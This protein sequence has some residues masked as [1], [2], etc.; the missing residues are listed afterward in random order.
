MPSLSAPV[1]SR[2]QVPHGTIELLAN[3]V[4]VT[5]V[6]CGLID[7]MCQDPA[8]GIFGITPAPYGVESGSG[9]DEFVGADHIVLVDV[10]NSSDGV[11]IR[12]P[13]FGIGVGVPIERVFDIFPGEYFLKPPDLNPGE[14][15]NDAQQRRSRVHNRPLG[16]F[17]IEG[18]EFLGHDGAQV[19]QNL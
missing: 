12:H 6:P 13:K 17:V 5:G 14:V 7:H 15:V 1:G 3:D 19:P 18:S 10:E 11:P 4:H 2:R 16:G 9:V 8:Q